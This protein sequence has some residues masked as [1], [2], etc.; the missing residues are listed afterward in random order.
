MNYL[1][2]ITIISI[3]AIMFAG[4]ALA[5]S[6]PTILLRN[7]RFS[8]DPINSV[9]IQ[10][11][12]ANRHALMQFERALSSSDKEELEARG[13]RLV[14][15][16]PENSWIVRF[17]GRLEDSDR[18]QFG[19]RWF[20]AIEAS[21]KISPLVSLLSGPSAKKMAD[22]RVS[23]AV[24][25]H[26]DADASVVTEQLRQTIG[27]EL[28]GVDPSTNTIDIICAV[29]QF[30]QIA[31]FDEV[32]WVEPYVLKQEEHNDNARSNLKADQAQAAPYNLDGEFIV[33]AEWDGGAVSTTHPDLSGRVTV[34]GGASTAA[35]ATHVGGT[36]I[37]NGTNSSG[38]YRGMAPAASIVSQLWWSSSS[39]VFSEYQNVLQAHGASLG[40]NSWGYSVGDPATQQACEDVLGTYFSVDATLDNIVRG[41][42]GRP[43][44][45]IFSAGNQRGTA[46]KYCGSLGW[47]YGT[48]DGLACSKNVLSIG[49]I[50]SNNSSMT[51]FSS[52]GPTDDGRIKPDVVGPGC[53][54][55]GDGGLTSTNT[56][57]GYTV[58]CGTSMS[59]PAVAGVVALMHQQ[60]YLS[61]G[62]QA[63][64]PSS[65][66]AI[67]V[68]S[69]TDLGSTGPDYQYGHGRVET[70]NAVKKVA[71]GSPSYIESQI[72]HGDVVQY[73]ITVPGATS[74]LK[75]T[76]AWD[77][78][79][80]TAISGNTLIND[81]DLVLIDPFGAETKPWVMNPAVPSASATRNFNRRDNVETAEVVSPSAGLWKARVTGFNIPDGPQ[82][83]SL[84]FTPDSI[85]QPGQS[86]AMAVYEEGDQVVQPGSS[87]PVN[88]WVS[89]VGGSQDSIRVRITDD[90]GWIS[91]T[92]DTTV[93][94]FPYDSAMFTV[95]ASVP[96][97]AFAIDSTI[98]TCRA[99]SQTD[100]TVV[101]TN[102][103][104]IR[105]A[106][107]YAL[108][109]ATVNAD[110]AN[111]PEQV[112]LS[113]KIR[114]EGNAV[115][116]FDIYPGSI[117]NW[118]VAPSYTATT[119]GPRDSTT[120]LFTLH[121]PEEV[122]HESDHII[123]LRVVGPGGT[124]DTS[125]VTFHT[126]NPVFPPALI[127]PDTVLYTQ[128][129][130]PLL[131]WDGAADSYTLLLGNDT[132]L[133]VVSRTFAGLTT[134]SFAW[135]PSDSLPDGE[136]FWAVKKYVSGDSSSIQRYPRRLV[137]DN[138]VPE[139]VELYS[140]VSG[141]ATASPHPGFAFSEP[142]GSGPG[143]APENT[144]LELA[145]DTGFTQDLIVYQ[146][147]IGTSF[148]VP[149]SLSDNRWYFRF[150]RLDLAGN[151]STPGVA[152]NLTVDT[153]VPDLPAELVPNNG[154]TVA[155]S[156]V[157]LRWTTTPLPS[158]TTS[159]E[160]YYLHVSTL[161]NFGDY[162]VTGYQYADS[163]SFGSAVAGTTY[164]WR[165]KSL[166]SAGH[167]TAFSVGRSFTY[168]PYTCGDVTGNGGSPDLT[169]LS[170]LIAY[171]VASGNPPPVPAAS[172]FDCNTTI[173]LTDLSIL[174]S[175]LTGGSTPLC[176]P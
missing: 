145:T 67:L 90:L 42:A 118:L 30:E 28:I 158:W 1:T 96:A 89:N 31:R 126:L 84:V 154:Q 150:R 101:T 123:S 138:I 127:S 26:A 14:A 156:P 77:D 41:S 35:H 117:D 6:A 74:R 81:L 166:D 121:I 3:A 157:L 33:V 63:I 136:Y 176:C 54:S 174:I 92:I 97:M 112:P 72:A 168:Q 79:G 172:S 25:L 134:T 44:T 80:G 52:W 64:L 17:E 16:V 91:T 107:T 20:G 151:I 131:Q 83:F 75:V 15:Y 46:S 94:L 18:G 103:T 160:Y 55:T 111:S 73:D 47:T 68:N 7:G 152:P 146:P 51:S 175:F 23:F 99:N 34:L 48:L 38:T 144:Q 21:Q 132:N 53:Q 57:T 125:E 164:Y 124:E 65:I 86:L 98:I 159:R 119:I 105:A 82:K 88:F 43:V 115:G 114:N 62:A 19:I 165:V 93:L 110:T 95:T 10:S 56:T 142:A 59:A 130:R 102:G 71:I 173:D 50:N 11:G 49:A 108:S 27:A 128:D 109:L 137:I 147:I 45:I 69:A 141:S 13:I 149:D 139:A 9:D 29:D 143:T 87:S 171:L 129:R 39:E 22:G 5:D 40:T 78:P 58:M 135:S 104:S 8:P 163:F 148:V 36:I 153:R 162:T 61:W 140:P 24:V 116:Q 32:Q 66:K 170:Y 60:Q 2:R 161:P 113:L 133:S 70:V 4:I 100:T 85:Y 120:L 169:D 76:L 12:L 122:L 167:A 37:G 106:T 155:T